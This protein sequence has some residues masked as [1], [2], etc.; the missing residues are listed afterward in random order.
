MSLD[1]IGIAG[2]EVAGGGRKR[3]IA[4]V[5][6]ERT[7][8]RLTVTLRSVAGE[9]TRSIECSLAIIHERVAH[10]IGITGDEI[11]GAG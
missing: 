5:S 6:A 4:A 10:S 9:F 2:D 8:A 11:A 7:D 1:A 3:H